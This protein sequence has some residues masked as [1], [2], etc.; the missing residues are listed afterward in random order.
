MVAP[1][2]GKIPDPNKSEDK[3]EQLSIIKALD[4]MGLKPDTKIQD[5]H[6]D[7]VFIGSCTNSRIEDLEA[8]AELSLIHI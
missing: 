8:A 3:D 6:I 1:I 2:T 7:K 5:I 4:Y